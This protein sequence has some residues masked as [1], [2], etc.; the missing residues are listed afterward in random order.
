MK[1]IFSETEQSSF[2]H[3]IIIIIIIVFINFCSRSNTQYLKG[4]IHIWFHVFFFI[5]QCIACLYLEIWL[6]KYKYRCWARFKVCCVSWI[7]RYYY[8][9]EFIKNIWKVKSMCELINFPKASNYCIKL[10][11]FIAQG[12]CFSNISVNFIT[13]TISRHW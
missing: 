4:E 6:C 1:T 3:I 8:K 9:S 12:K 7:K 2:E 10:Y 11:F 13:E 5:F